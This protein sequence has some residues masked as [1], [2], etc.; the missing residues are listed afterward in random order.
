MMVSLEVARVI[1]TCGGTA[2]EPRFTERPV[3]SCVLACRHG[4]GA[5]WYTGI[6]PV[7]VYVTIDFRLIANS[8]ETHRAS[9]QLRTGNFG[10]SSTHHIWSLRYV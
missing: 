1:S 2:V 5:G 9:Q 8:R 4:A 6:T 7:C 3:C 10:T